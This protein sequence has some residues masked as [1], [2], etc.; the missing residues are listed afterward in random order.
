MWYPPE[1]WHLRGRMYL[2]LWWVRGR[3]L[4]ATAWVR[5]GPGGVLTYDEL[6]CAVP[7]RVGARPSTTIVDIWVDSPQSLAGGR[8]LW[9]IPKELAE[10]AI[11][12]GRFAATA[13]GATIASARL[14]SGRRLPGRVPFRFTVT[15]ARDGRPLTSPVRGTARVSLARARWSPEPSGPLGYLAGRRPLLTLAL[16]DFRMVFG[17][18]R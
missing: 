8:E 5:Y 18:R 4:V 7:A 6:L 10:F 3:G 17:R 14:E 16:T 13:G 12:G 15:Q 1:P 2:S 9:G 11:D